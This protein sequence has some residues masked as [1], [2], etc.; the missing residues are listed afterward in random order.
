[1]KKYSFTDNYF[2][3]DDN[4]WFPIV[5]EFHYSFCPNKYWAETLCKMTSAGVEIIFANVNWHHHEKIENEFDFSGD[6]NLNQ[7]VKICQKC[8]VKILLNIG[9]CEDDS[10]FDKDFSNW[11]LEKDFASHP[12]NQ[13]YFSAVR[14]WF[15]KIFEQVNGFLYG[16]S[17]NAPIVGIQIANEYLK[18]GDLPK[19]EW[20]NLK[21]KLLDIAKNVGFN[22]PFYTALNWEGCETS[23]YCF[24]VNAKKS[25]CLVANLCNGFKITYNKRPVSSSNDIGA[26]SLIK[27]GSGQNI[28]GF[29]YGCRNLKEDFLPLQKCFEFSKKDLAIKSCD[30]NASIKEFGQI[31]LIFRE[32]KLFS[33]FV[34]HYGKD[35]CL[36][37]SIIPDDDTN[38]SN[39]F[40][41]FDYCFRTNGEKGYLFVNNYVYG[42][43]TKLHKNIQLFLPNSEDSFRLRMVKNEEYFFLPFNIQYGDF[44][45][46]RANVSP[47]CFLQNENKKIFVFYARQNEKTFDSLFEFDETKTNQNAKDLLLVLSREDA[48]NGFK[49]NDE[50]LFI[51]NGVIVQDMDNNIIFT[52]TENPEF[53]AYP[54]LK[55]V[56]KDFI[57]LQDE[58]KN[59]YSTEFSCKYG[60]DI[61]FAKYCLNKELL[62]RDRIDIFITE[63][64]NDKDSK[65]YFCLDFSRLANE[66]LC[67]KNYS[68]CFVKIFYK[69]ESAKLYYAKDENQLLSTHFYGGKNHYFEIGLK[70]FVDM[71][72]D[73]SKLKLEINPFFENDAI[74]IEENNIFAD[75]KMCSLVTIAYNFEWKFIL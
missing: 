29:S 51:T 24:S 6:K 34:L 23:D 30:L 27:L 26:M 21:K 37:D 70:T 68:N 16:Q 33:I 74:H 40:E 17:E 71:N 42:K 15:S 22:V 57:R 67:N 63:E 1:M 69:G 44:F 3:K 38:K 58:N 43:K 52:S 60:S 4:P 25:S 18:C 32:L 66:L 20:D 59:L 56:P 2:T 41:N 7:F 73:L 12:N 64:K 28:L 54:P 48:L 45:V 13:L 36:F 53:F 9:F 14:K 72:F 61:F 10:F 11:L 49:T 65:K 75:G 35:F 46:K 50:T 5:G 8:N 19:I 31:S 47:F 39:F 55:N 62:N